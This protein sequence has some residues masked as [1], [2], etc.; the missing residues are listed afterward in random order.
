MKRNR[1]APAKQMP[2]SLFR[3][4]SQKIIVGWMPVLRCFR[5]AVEIK[6]IPVFIFIYFPVFRQWRLKRVRWE[7]QHVAGNT[8]H[9]QRHL[10]QRQQKAFD[11]NIDAQVFRHVTHLLK[12]KQTVAQ[13]R[14]AGD[15]KH[16]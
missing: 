7:A 1:V 8:L 4:F 2:L 9:L 10:G 14:S 5:N 13:A 3:N 11:H 16:S 15:A 12:E 6:R